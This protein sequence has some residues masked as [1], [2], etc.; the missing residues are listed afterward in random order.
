MQQLE[1]IGVGQQ[2]NDGTGDP[3]RD[4]MVKVNANFV[5]TQAG[6]DSVEGN[7]ASVK[8]TADAAKVKADAAVPSAQKGVPNG[9]APLGPDGRVPTAHIGSFIKQ[10]DRGAA[11][12]V[13]PLGG[14][15]KVPSSNLPD[16]V[17]S[18]QKGQPNGVATLAGDGKVPTAQLP[19]I[20]TI[21]TGF[22]TWWPSRD[23]IPAGWIPGDGQAVS[24]ALFPGLA[25]AVGGGVLPAIP[26][27]DWWSNPEW[28]GRYTTINNDPANIR[29][30]DYNGKSAGS[31]GRVFLSGDGENSASSAGVIQRDAIQN[32]TGSLRVAYGVHQG[33]NGA[34][35]G[36][37][38]PSSGA[39][40]YSLSGATSDIT[41][42][43]S[44]IARTAAETRPKNV[45][46]CFIIK[47]FGVV[48]NPGSADAAQLASSLA[49]L[50]ASF[51]S[52]RAGYLA[53]LGFAMVYPGGSASSP[54]LAITNA[55]YVTANPFPGYRVFCQ[56]EILYDG[57]WC[58]P[59]WGMWYRDGAYFAAGVTATQFNDG[60]IVVQTGL[61]SLMTNA[62][63]TGANFSPS[64][65]PSSAQVRVLC[66]KA[67]G[68][69]N[70]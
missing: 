67:K 45:T 1:H 12:G 53:D 41:F 48:V 13:A 40:S 25:A 30:P 24:R 33:G 47:A 17:L 28:R 8:L 5:K 15:A 3:L 51:Q 19:P 23:S 21:P 18:S 2:E 62:E 20:D 69:I 26:E 4:G 64:A 27:S 16:L 68:K 46:G 56:A 44:R 43:A 31:L 6:I 10:D 60:D 59:G 49:A 52:H 11:N 66:W 22:V 39:A 61:T 29:V 65:A 50:S 58:K 54:G 34:F 32:I 7:L 38:G 42:D 35:M 36:A 57:R 63:L 70:G 14:D 55:R 9:V 37:T